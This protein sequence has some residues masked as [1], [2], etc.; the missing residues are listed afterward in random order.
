MT[1]VEAIIVACI[2][3]LVLSPFV[4]ATARKFIRLACAVVLAAVLAL[5]GAE[6]VRD[7]L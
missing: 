6:I 2:F 3:A 4:P 7:L 1:W 5:Y